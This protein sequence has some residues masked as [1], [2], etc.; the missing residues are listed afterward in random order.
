[1][2]EVQWDIKT[3]KLIVDIE[4]LK[5]S[6]FNMKYSSNDYYFFKFTWN[7]FVKNM[8]ESCLY[9]DIGNY[10]CLDRSKYASMSNYQPVWV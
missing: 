6:Y 8:I 3:D 10:G 1:M 9:I 2:K 5:T 4:R 7:D